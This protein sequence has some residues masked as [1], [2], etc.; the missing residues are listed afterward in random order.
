MSSLRQT[1]VPHRTQP[2]PALGFTSHGAEPEAILA[3]AGDL[4][5]P[6]P[7]GYALG[8]RG[9]N[10]NEFGE[11]LSALAT[12][13]LGAVLQA[14]LPVILRRDLEHAVTHPVSPLSPAARL[15]T[16]N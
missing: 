14:M 15:L 6:A 3:L 13:N 5:D 12:A 16:E 4:S 7:T 2:Q 8:I 10:F 11:Y 9:Y 1:T